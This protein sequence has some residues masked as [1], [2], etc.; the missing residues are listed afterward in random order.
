MFRKLGFAVL[1]TS[2]L[3]MSFHVSSASAHGRWS[4]RHIDRIDR[5]A[6]RHEL[7]AV[8]YDRWGW[9]DQYGDYH[10]FE[11]SD[12]WGWYD[13]YGNYHRFADNY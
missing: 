4:I 3:L 1:A 12:R 13:S 6:E 5:F 2:A 7:Y 9:Y 11:R 8:R 10:R